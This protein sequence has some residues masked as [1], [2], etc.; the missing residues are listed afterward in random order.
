M[1]IQ[2]LVK[3]LLGL[4]SSSPQVSPELVVNRP[5]SFGPVLGV[6]EEK[7]RDLIDFGFLETARITTQHS[8]RISVRAFDALLMIQYPD[9]HAAIF[10]FDSPFQA[11]N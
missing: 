5:E 8:I 3:D 4:D 11:F 6:D 10:Q 9:V 1:V 7:G 2:E